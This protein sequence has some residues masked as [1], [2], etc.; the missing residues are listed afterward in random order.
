MDKFYYCFNCEQTCE[1]EHCPICGEVTHMCS[2]DECIECGRPLGE[3]ICTKEDLICPYC[4]SHF[5][6]IDEIRGLLYCGSC[7]RYENE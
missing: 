4:G 5:C 2:D 3:C 6:S 1:T 7:G